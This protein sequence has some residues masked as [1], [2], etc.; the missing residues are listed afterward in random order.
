MSAPPHVTRPLLLVALLLLAAAPARASFVLGGDDEPFQLLVGGWIQPTLDVTAPGSDPVTQRMRL[1]RARMD[2]RTTVHDERV[3]ARIQVDFGG[4]GARVLD[5]FVDVELH[6]LVHV[7]VGRAILP[8]Q[9]QWGPNPATL[10]FNSRTIT[11]N[12]FAIPGGRDVQL[13]L[14]GSVDRLQYGLALANGRFDGSAAE[15]FGLSITGRV[16]GAL[17]GVVHDDELPT[18]AVEGAHV[19]AGLGGYAAFDSTWRDWTHGEGGDG[20]PA[21]VQTAFAELRLRTGGL[22]LVLDGAIQRV[23][24]VPVAGFEPTVGGGVQGTAAFL[25]PSTPLVV[26]G[27]YGEA[28]TDLDDTTNATRRTTWGGGLTALHD[29][30]RWYTRLDLTGERAARRD[31]GVPFADADTVTT[32]TLTHILRF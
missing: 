20:L 1:Q 31:A 11:S 2:L 28:R 18:R 8:H 5:A 23:D 9:N 25:V 7:L 30:A 24:A 14:H 26:A 12:L 27:R 4:S 10:A 17:V 3:D 21:D 13:Q 6:P 22:T 15:T 32:L 19:M 29:G 16:L